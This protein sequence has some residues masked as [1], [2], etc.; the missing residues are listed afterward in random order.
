[1]PEQQQT[2]LDRMGTSL[3]VC[4]VGAVKDHNI[5][6][7]RVTFHLDGSECFYFSYGSA[8]VCT[9]HGVPHSAGV[10]CSKCELVLNRPVPELPSGVVGE[11]CSRCGSSVAG[12]S[13][14]GPLVRSSLQHGRAARM[15]VAADAG[16]CWSK[17]PFY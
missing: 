1:M 9:F 15:L 11:A 6:F 14:I 2:L 17:G 8:H 12:P 3:V 13:S 7:E 4:N 16:V 5:M 10:E